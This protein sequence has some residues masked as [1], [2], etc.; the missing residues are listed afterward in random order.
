MVKTLTETFDARDLPMVRRFE[1]AEKAGPFVT[2]S[3]LDE[4]G[5][6]LR[7]LVSNEGGCVPLPLVGRGQGWGWI[8]KASTSLASPR[9]PLP[10]LPH[11]G[12][13]N[14]MSDQLS[15]HPLE[16]A[17]DIIDDVAGL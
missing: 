8:S 7:M 15:A 4:D 1:A 6:I 10:T 11:K 16:L 9:A 14:K 2:E 5:R 12:G 17:T 13:G 3:R